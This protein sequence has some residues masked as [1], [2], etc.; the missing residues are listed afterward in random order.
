[1]ILF[2]RK[3]NQEK[4]N[5]LRAPKKPNY[6][7]KTYQLPSGYCGPTKRLGKDVLIEP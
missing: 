5:I 2:S 7:F 6:E 4:Q 1:M 3:R